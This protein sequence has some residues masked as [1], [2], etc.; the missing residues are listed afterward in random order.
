MLT[1]TLT[2]VNARGR[3]GTVI[4][5]KEK[6]SLRMALLL[7]DVSLYQVTWLYTAPNFLIARRPHSKETP[8]ALPCEVSK[9]RTPRLAV[10]TWGGD[11]SK[12]S[13]NPCQGTKRPDF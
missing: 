10:L 9:G 3:D 1:L 2:L 12:E 8:L 11:V 7:D 4:T 13:V 6:V 5:P